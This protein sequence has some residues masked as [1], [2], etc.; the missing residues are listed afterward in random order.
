MELT[1]AEI[2][3]VHI[4]P[5]QAPAGQVYTVKAV[6]VEYKL[7]DYMIVQPGRAPYEITQELYSRRL[8]IC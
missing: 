3:P 5:A 1:A 7:Q 2:Y 4:S 6:G 8:W